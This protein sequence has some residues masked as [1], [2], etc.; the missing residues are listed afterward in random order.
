MYVI[1]NNSEKRY[2]FN[3]LPYTPLAPFESEFV[4]HWINNYS[5]S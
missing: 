2:A 5:R 3:T 1:Q 4:I